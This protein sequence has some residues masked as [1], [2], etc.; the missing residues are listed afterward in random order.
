[1]SD[2]PRLHYHFW[3]LSAVSVRVVALTQGI[4]DFAKDRTVHRLLNGS[5]GSDPLIVQSG[6]SASPFPDGRDS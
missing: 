2:V 3:T 6:G 4:A 1:M 5:F